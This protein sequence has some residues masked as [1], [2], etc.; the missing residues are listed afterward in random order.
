MDLSRALRVTGIPWFATITTAFNAR[1]I[2]ISA[3]PG[4]PDVEDPEREQGGE[5]RVEE[6]GPERPADAG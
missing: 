2:R 6:D 3:N 5:R 1:P 4:R